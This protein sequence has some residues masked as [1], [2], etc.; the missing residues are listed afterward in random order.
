LSVCPELNVQGALAS[1]LARLVRAGVLDHFGQV[2]HVNPMA[3]RRA[4]EVVIATIDWIAGTARHSRWR[5][6]VCAAGHGPQTLDAAWC[7]GRARPTEYTHATA[8][9]T[10]RRWARLPAARAAGICGGQWT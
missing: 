8:G 10:Q 2:A 4:L 9:V 7:C 5:C 3:A 1:R 6:G